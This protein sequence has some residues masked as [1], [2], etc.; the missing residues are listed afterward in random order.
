MASRNHLYLVDG[1]SYIFR[2][3]HQLPP[4]TNRH[5]TPA[6]AVYGYTAM[7]WK[8]ADALDKEEGPT[9]LAVILDKGSHTF[10]NDLYDQYKAHRPPPPEDLIPQFPLI[11]EATRAFSLPCIEEAGFEAD[12]IIATYTCQAVAQGWDVTIVSSDKDLAQLIQPGVD[13]LDTMKNERRGPDYVQDKFGVA[14]EQLRDV[15]A[16]M[17]DSVDN[18][19]GVPGVGAKT[20]AKLIGEYGDL[21]AVLAAA[22]DM[23]PSKL[24]E[25]LIEHAELA[26]LSRELVTLHCEVPLPHALDDLKLDG[27]PA[28]PL[29]AFLED[30]GFKALLARM[31]SHAPGRQT[32]DPVAEAVVDAALDPTTPDFIPLP[33]IN[34]ESYETVTTLERLDAWIAQSYASGIIAIDTETDS[35]DSMAANL[36]GICLATAPGTACYIPLGHRSG[37][38]MF[39]EAPPQIPMADALARLRPLFA[40]A[41]VLKIGH[42]IKYDLNVLARHGLS[43]TPFDDTLVMSFDL[44]AGQSLAGHGMDEVAHA[45][46]EHTCISF[47]DVTGT[48][49]KAISFAQVPLD[50]ATRYGGEDADVTWRLWTRFKPRLAQE[51][52]TRVYELVDRPLIPVVAGME[53]SGI[54]V[55]R[56]HLSRLSGRFA[57]EMARLEE[58]I[59]AEAG[60]PFAIGSTQQLGAIL[61]EK[62]GLKGGKKGK[63]GA[64][65]TDVTVLERMKADGVKIAGLVLDWR[66]LSKLKSTYTDALQ[67]QINHDTGR[68]HTSYSLTGAQ[69][70]RLSSTDPNLQN[71]PIRT[72]TGRQIRDAFIAEQGN[73]ILAADYSQIELR[74]AAHMADVPQLRDAFLRGEDIHAATAQELFGEMNRET[75]ARAKTINFAILYGISRWGLAARLEIDADEAQAMISRYFDRFPGISAYINETLEKVRSTGHTTTLFGRKTWFNQIKSPVQHVRQGAERAAI[76]APIQG[77]S[78]DIIK[79]AMVRMGPAL[80]DA[81]L[82]RVKMLLQVHDELVFELPEDDVA[83]ATPIIRSVMASAAEPLVKLTVPLGVEIGTGSSWGAAH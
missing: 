49:K 3:Y 26:R 75:R 25:R 36:V 51:G 34:C 38:D 30:Q 82:D 57:Q 31:A 68:V 61:F 11:R 14:P 39:A 4:L 6:G 15:L 52:A 44:D 37:D 66:Q 58:E 23:K 69:T 55:D 62:M 21:D 72:E 19:P 67:A 65:S 64:Y 28:E 2:A 13:M 80:R 40:D 27:I 63:S 8:L 78:A 74:L 42:N 7:L 22:P 12:D 77:T 47:K 33:P 1:S 50:A 18:V 83:A 48:G 60:Q 54:K 76:N 53:R 45:V 46:L 35:L 81:G 9:H 71:I 56:D 5:G 17:G 59:H 29:R 24:K 73:V 70:G 43:V 79:R 16:L 32:A 10:R 20:A 41:S